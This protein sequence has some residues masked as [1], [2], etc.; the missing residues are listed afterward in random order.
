MC[1]IIYNHEPIV[2][3]RSIGRK[4]APRTARFVFDRER[5]SVYNGMNKTDGLQ[6]GA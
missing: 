6:T 4:R 5:G 2:L 1:V 3:Y